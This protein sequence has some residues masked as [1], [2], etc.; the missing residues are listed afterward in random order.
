MQPNAFEQ[1]GDTIILL[2]NTKALRTLGIFLVAIGLGVLVLLVRAV[3]TPVAGYLF[4]GIE[5]VIGFILIYM[6]GIY[7]YTFNRTIKTFTRQVKT[8]LRNTTD[9]WR[10]NDIKDVVLKAQHIQPKNGRG[11]Y[12]YRVMVIMESGKKMKVFT[13]RQVEESEKVL[14]QIRQQVF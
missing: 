13:H 2:Q 10:F 14:Q 5:L 8:W 7:T 4:P 9:T 1:S 11:Y 3:N 6:G 12:E